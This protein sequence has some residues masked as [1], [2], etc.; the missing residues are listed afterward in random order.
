M[1]LTPLAPIESLAASEVNFGGRAVVQPFTVAPAIVV[2]DKFGNGAFEVARQVGVL[3][4][5]ALFG[6]VADERC[7]R[8]PLYPQ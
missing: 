8:S 7:P 4:L 5:H 3:E 6:R 1:F 2:N